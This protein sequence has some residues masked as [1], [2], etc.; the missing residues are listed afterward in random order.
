MLEENK[1]TG[2]RLFGWQPKRQ[3]NSNLFQFQWGFFK[4]QF[5][6]TNQG[7]QNAI[8]KHR[9][10]P[11]SVNTE[12]YNIFYKFQYLSHLALI[13]SQTLKW[14]C[15][16]WDDE[17]KS[18]TE[19]DFKRCY[20]CLFY[21]VHYITLH[22]IQGEFSWSLYCLAHLY[23]YHKRQHFAF[24]VFF[25]D[26]SSHFRQRKRRTLPV[27]PCPLLGQICAYFSWLCASSLVKQIYK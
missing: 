8:T 22:Y 6:M 26:F 12:N 11:P 18:T 9:V 17:Q 10:Q 27:K 20:S 1:L 2:W 24:R 16:V 13:G 14:L 5:A 4:V 21:S 7:A 3:N 19:Q 15:C 25:S 23:E